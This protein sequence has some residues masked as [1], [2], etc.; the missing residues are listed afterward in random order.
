M[1]YGPDVARQTQ[2]L[3][4]NAGIQYGGLTES[5]TTGP[6]V[7]TLSVGGTVWAV[8]AVTDPQFGTAQ[9]DQFGVTPMSPA[10]YLAIREAA[11]VSDV[12]CVSIH[13]GQEQTTIPSPMRRELFRSFVDA[14]AHLVWGHHPH[15][16]QVW[17]HYKNGVIFYGLGNFAVTPSDWGSDPRYLWSLGARVTVSSESI[18]VSP[19]AFRIAP[20]APHAVSELN[21]SECV[22]ALAPL[23][24]LRGMM[25]TPGWHEQ[26]WR[27]VAKRLYRR[28]IAP[29]M[30]WGMRLKHRLRLRLADFLS[31]LGL[32]KPKNY[33]ALHRFHLVANTAHQEVMVE[34]LWAD[35]NPQARSSVPG[36]ETDLHALFAE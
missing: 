16:A 19:T 33:L 21:R 30:G 3:L 25:D 22:R 18:T 12:V 34:G 14:G 1:D 15:V 28:D 32:H 24:E 6:P 29:S 2:T 35:V 5:T 31:A 10:L 9:A 17:E 36:I 23:E 8:I 27:L 20:D 4:S 26:A 11:A 7:T 13:A